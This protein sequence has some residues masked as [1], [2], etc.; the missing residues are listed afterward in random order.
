[1]S[2]HKLPDIKYPKL[3]FSDLTGHVYII[4]N[5][6]HD[7]IDVTKDFELIA[8]AKQILKK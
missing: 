6:N 5:K 7:K 4:V 1:M 3:G 8:K 2:I